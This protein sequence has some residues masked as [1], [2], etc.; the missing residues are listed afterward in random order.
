[1]RVWVA[2][3]DAETWYVA[4]M[5][6]SISKYACAVLGVVA[7]QGSGNTMSPTLGNVGDTHDTNHSSSPNDTMTS[8]GTD[9]AA[10]F[11]KSFADPGG[12]WLPAQMLLPQH[13]D[14]FKKMGVR[15]DA[16]TLSDP[17]KEPLAAV[18]W[19]GGC[20][21]SFVSPGGLIV[22][23]HHCVQE[24]LQHNSTPDSNLVENGFLAKTL[25]DE[26]PAGPAQRVMVVQK[27]TDITNEM[28]DGLDKIKDPVARKDEVDK[29]QK[30]FVATCEKGRPG[31]RCQVSAFF[32]QG[33][34]Q[35]IEMLEIRDVRLVY[36]P[37]R[38]VGN[39]G[40]EEDNWKWPRHTG[41][42][43]FYR[44][45][46]GKDGQP[47]DYA[48]ENVPYRPAHYLKVSTAGV[49]PGDFVMVTGYPART[50]R[51]ATAAAIHHDI[52]TRLPYRI[53]DAKARYALVEEHLKD[54]G[55]TAIKA[56]VRKQRTQN[57]LA[58]NEGVLKG[59]TAGE[60]IQQKDELETKIKA[61]AEQPGHEA[62][63]AAL[64]RLDQIENDEVKT[65][66]GDF[67]RQAV[68]G[69]SMLLASALTLTHWAEERQKKDPDRKPGFQDRDMPRAI[70]SQKQ[71]ARSYDRILDRAQ[72]RLEL[73]RALADKDSDHAWLALL[74]DTRKGQKIDE[75]LIDKTLT[76]WFS[77]PALE[78]TKTRLEL[79]EKGTMS[80]LRESKDPFV[81]AAQ[82][83][84][85]VVKAEEKKDDARSGELVLVAPVYAEAM[86]EVLGGMLA[87][88][89]NF[90]LR[91]TY[92]TVKAFKQDSR[93]PAD[94]PQTMAS[95]ILAK[96][97]GK[98]P[99]DSPKKLVD[100]IK[101]KRFGPYADR[102]LGGDLPIDFM[103]DLDITG[104]NSG[105]PT[106][107]DKGELVGLAF[108][109]NIE[110]VASDVVFNPAT[111]RSIH[112]DA[113]Y[114]IWTMDALDNAKHLIKEMGLEPKL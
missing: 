75:A 99:F 17:L 72:L 32:R 83:V 15:M 52:D 22:T 53:D 71:F 9:P 80:Q 11:R 42:W 87:P 45:Y 63:K 31:T 69:S 18:V 98:P 50:E 27:Y 65:F 113:R 35:L 86:R 105:S 24:A 51:T 114:M 46:V 7:C 37:A 85:P 5:T 13:E 73:V 36:V 25:A 10:M 14:N 6:R 47:A 26:K 62:A 95:Q 88:D 58:K 41:D 92:G 66:R 112:V 12:M 94:W 101:S 64:A 39:Y 60:L 8:T 2:P 3:D 48:T 108:D 81:R 16:K 79:L 29:R 90:T 49:K 28:R 77:A 93:D 40:G 20:T 106:L 1:M 44:A 33:M 30:Q 97:T 19:L 84:W 100:A 96:D 68:L 61:W 78:D 104:G 91:I 21:A 59:L 74:L 4:D 34:F 109:G 23:N 110:G 89:A 57:G 111:T 54:G 55:E 43:S 102:R 76:A 107:N 67:D 82:R 38:S 56:G 70:A 103:S